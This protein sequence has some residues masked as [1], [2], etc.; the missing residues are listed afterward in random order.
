MATARL[1]GLAGAPPPVDPFRQRP[2]RVPSRL[3]RLGLPVALFLV[4]GVL[5]VVPIAML[6]LG[7]FRDAPPGAGG[8]WTLEGWVSAYTDRRTYSTLIVTVLVAVGALAGAT[9]VALLLAWIVTRTDTPGRQ[10]LERLLLLPLFIPGVLLA[11]AWTVL[12]SPRTGYLNRL[13]RSVPGL[14]WFTFDVYTGYGLVFLF[15]LAVTPL[16]YFMLLP[17][18]KG[19]DHSLEEAAAA[20]GAGRLV[21]A[22]RIALPLAAPAILGGGILVAIKAI[23]NLEVPAILKGGSGIDVF[24]TRV[25]FAIRL[26]ARPDYAQAAA[27]GAAVVLCTAVLV[28]IQ[29]R[30]LSKRDYTTVGSR[31][32]NTELVALGAW[33]FVTA[34]LCWTYL[35]FAVVVPMLVV[36]L[37]SFEPVFGLGRPGQL[38]LDNWQEVLDDDTFSSALRNTITTAGLSTAIVTVLSG[39]VAYRCVRSPRGGGR[40]LEALSWIPW[41]LPGPVLG[42]GLL[43]GYAL[44][45]G[46]FYLSRWVLVVAYTT[47]LL[48]LGVRMFMS[49][50]RQLDVQLEEAA[51]VAGSGAFRMSV[52]IIS[53]LIART[54][55]AC[56]VIGFVLSVREVG[57]PAILA[58]RDTQVLGSLTLNLWL[59]GE[60]SHA[61][62]A[63]VVMVSLCLAALVVQVLVDVVVQRH[64]SADERPRA[65]SRS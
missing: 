8:G 61:A 49:A 29:V 13:V 11:L 53:P 46:Q 6:A 42:L 10:V 50:F 54:I 31:G 1:E 15:G 55:T 44:L 35:A 62:V 47:I 23:E 26:N 34:L 32:A 39:L 19:M 7:S 63:G 28:V 38:T 12:G 2:R 14:D 24:M 20:A 3:S 41:S 9:P 18:L 21:T 30:Y 37:G 25:F 22:F 27:L 4:V 5:T 16:M 33:R 45:P 43:W 52:V 65:P 64:V 56:L 48:P 59:E 17:V 36:V 40:G 58:T 51:A 60:A 57:M